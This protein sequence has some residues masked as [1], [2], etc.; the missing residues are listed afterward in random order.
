MSSLVGIHINNIDNIKKYKT[1]NFFQFFV[2]QKNKYTKLKNVHSVIHASYTIN[3]ARN[4]TENEWWIIQLINEIEICQIIG[5][6]CIVIHVGKKLNLSLEEAINNMYSAL[7]YIHQQT[8]NTGV[9]ILIET[10]AGQGTE[11]LE[12]IKD[13]CKFMLKFFNHPDNKIKERFGICIDTCH[14]YVAGNKISSLIKN[15]H[16]IC[17][18]DKVK[19]CHL[20]SSKNDF[21]S[22]IDRHES[23]KNG[24]IKLD[25]LILFLKKLKIPII[26]ETPDDNIMDDYKYVGEIN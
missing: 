1:I 10:P 6:F 18:I 24:K 9:K 22:R 20:N 23:I 8:K 19:L 13:L 26:L 15:I 4:W 11:I 5:S 17:G 2:N 21:G 12:N 25:E 14:L 16:N 7:L 3:L